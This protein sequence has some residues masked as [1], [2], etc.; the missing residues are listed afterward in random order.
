MYR[1]LSEDKKLELRQQYESRQEYMVA[2]NAINVTSERYEDLSP[3]EIWNEAIA[4]VEE[5]RKSAH[6]EWK[7]DKVFNQL[8][9]KYSVFVDE[10]DTRVQRSEKQQE[11]TATLVLFDVVCMLSLAE[12][13]KPEEAEQHPYFEYMRTILG[14][15]CESVLFQAMLAVLKHDEEEVENIVGH[16]LQEVDYMDGVP[17]AKPVTK[18]T[19]WD[20][21]KFRR[22][23]L[24]KIY[25]ALKEQ[26]KE[27]FKGG[28][29]WFYVYR[30]MADLTIYADNSYK[31]FASDLEAIGVTKK[32]MPNTNTFS[33]KQNQLKQGTRYPNWQVKTGGKQTVLDEGK[34]IAQIAFNIINA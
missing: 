19:N 2:Y 18:E 7:V 9:R 14:Y 21:D 12:R 5:I 24:R 29:Q 23:C 32:H 8:K 33:R 17:A 15:F 31:P 4:V 25:A 34:R 3:E 16:D 28:S 22:S 27:Q 11:M 20:D 6:R 26:L 10:S 1:L 30:V 13:V